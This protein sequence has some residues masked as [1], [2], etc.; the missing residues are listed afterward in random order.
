MMFLSDGL[1]ENASRARY[2]RD[3]S[4]MVIGRSEWSVPSAC[5][6]HSMELI[7]CH[8]GENLEISNPLAGW[9]AR[10]P[11]GIISGLGVTPIVICLLSGRDR[12]VSPD[13]FSDS[14]R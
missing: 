14:G 10:A 2:R 1:K 6:V 9:G 12:L 13:C 7:I 11:V 3:F 5:D 4:R 8:S